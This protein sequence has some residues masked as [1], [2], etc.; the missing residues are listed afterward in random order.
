MS[1]E[2]AAA[3]GVS[4]GTRTYDEIDEI[5]ESDGSVLVVP[6]GSIEQ[7][8]KH[9]PVATDSILVGAIARLGAERVA[10]D[11]P[12]LALPPFWSGFSPHHLD[13]GGTVSLEFDHMLAAVEDIA[14]TALENGFDA[15]LL[16]NGHGGNMPLIDGA[17][18]TIGTD[19]DDVEVLG[20]TYFQLANAFMDEIRE[21]DI[22][23]MA[24]GGEFET[25][26]MLYLREELVRADRIDGTYMDEPYDLGTKDLVEGGPLAVYR[27]FEE[28]SASGAIGDPGLASA[29][30][31]ERIYERLGDELESLLR[32][33]HDRNR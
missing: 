19:H 21:S 9:L 17:V 23:G 11:V 13:F 26:L 28:Y 16:L 5:G 7:H 8:G 4:W 6:V 2:G 31:G 10:E 14:D 30:K 27:G 33:I 20:L 22:G 3:S 29:E 24:H 18:S 25:S 32:D 12:I 15:L 1:F